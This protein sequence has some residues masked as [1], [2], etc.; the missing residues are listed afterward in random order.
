[1][2]QIDKESSCRYSYHMNTIS[3]GKEDAMFSVPSN[4]MSNYLAILKS[5]EIPNTQTTY[6]QKWFRYFYDF[7][8][9]HPGVNN[10]AELVTKFQE[11][12][13][14][15]NQSVLQCR[16][17]AHAVLIYYEMN[18][19][20]TSL[21]AG[22]ANSAHEKYCD[23]AS[24]RSTRESTG[25]TSSCKQRHSQYSVA[26]HEEKSDSPEWDEVI[27]KL[28]DEI[29]V[30]HYSRKT[31]KIYAQWSRQFQ[32]F[33]KNKPPQELTT[34]DVK[35]YLTWL[36]VK[37]HVAAS[38]QN[39]AFNSLL[40]LFRHALKR[41]FGQLRDVPRAK[42]S[43]YIPVVLSRGEIDAIVQHLYHPYS[44]VVKM[45]FGCGLRE[46]EALQL[47][48]RDFDFDG[49]MLTVHGKGKKD[50]TVPLPESA[51]DE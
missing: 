37:C 2:F 23:T 43:L 1:M 20:V 42:K 31:L 46:F 32:K 10:K 6:Y 4:V 17:A 3:V 15:R 41:D 51:M 36:A 5:R 26:G 24:T 14:C 34:D 44:L 16:Q 27:G 39:Q 30:R 8:A 33:L 12:L 49:N 22:D 38:T 35:E 19:A 50:R 25:A 47:R 7:C 45:L 11:K 48:M 28:A 9:N 29:K 40:F 13:R 21:V 18:G